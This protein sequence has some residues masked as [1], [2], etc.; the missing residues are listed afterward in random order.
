MT[1]AGHGDDCS[2]GADT[3]ATE[4]AGVVVSSPDFSDDA[5]D[6][7]PATLAV[8]VPRRVFALAVATLPPSR[9]PTHSDTGRE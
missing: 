9:L 8:A 4:A 5:M 6:D 7:L 2:E 3:V 1:A